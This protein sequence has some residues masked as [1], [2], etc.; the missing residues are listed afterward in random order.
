MATTGTADDG[1]YSLF[2]VNPDT[3]EVLFGADGETV[4]HAAP[5]D[6]TVTDGF[7]TAAEG[8][9]LLTP[10]QI[11]DN[12]E[13]ISALTL[14]VSRD[15]AIKVQGVR[16]AFKGTKTMVYN[17]ATD[18]ITDTLTGNTYTVQKIDKS[19]YFVDANGNR[20]AQ[21]WLQNV[22]MANF[23]DLFTNTSLLKQLGGAF[24]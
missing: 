12:Y 8:Y 20:L 18:T 13:A 24:V 5:G 7:V 10:Q 23:R 17:E 2:L 6:V 22:G 3:H 21:S 1:P 15:S 16:N 9:S 14:S 11:N 4:R 19:E